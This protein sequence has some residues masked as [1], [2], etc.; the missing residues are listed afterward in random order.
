MIPQRPVVAVVDHS[1]MWANSPQWLDDFPALYL[2]PE[3]EVLDCTRRLLSGCCSRCISCSVASRR[4]ASGYSTTNSLDTSSQWG[5]HNRKLGTSCSCP[6]RAHCSR[7]ARP[8]TSPDSRISAHCHKP[9]ASA[10][11]ARPE[12][13][14]A[15]E[16]ALAANQ[17]CWLGNQRKLYYE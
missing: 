16:T 9:L 4:S 13:W 17:I 6:D 3:L 2:P 12:P 11:C 1:P 14:P 15:A 10:R 7:I 8:R 5:I